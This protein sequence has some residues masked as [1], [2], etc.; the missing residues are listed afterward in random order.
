M[1]DLGLSDL[2]LPQGRSNARILKV[3]HKVILLPNI[4]SPVKVYTKSWYQ[5]LILWI[6]I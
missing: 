5:K 6:A 2:D 1:F 3:L 4:K